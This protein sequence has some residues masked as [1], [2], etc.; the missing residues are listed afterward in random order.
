MDAQEKS[1]DSVEQTAKLLVTLA[2]SF[3]AFSVAFSKE[4]DGFNLESCLDISTFSLF[5]CFML[6]SISLGIWTLLGVATV[7][8]PPE[9]PNKYSPTIRDAKIKMPFAFQIIA[10]GI[11]VLIFILFGFGKIF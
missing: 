8:E 2:T 9:K 11:G 7:L 5:Y 10:F 3:V 6:V 1:F 4:L